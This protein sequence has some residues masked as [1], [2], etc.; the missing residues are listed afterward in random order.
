[1]FCGKTGRHAEG[2]CQQA[3]D[4]G[5]QSQLGKTHPELGLQRREQ[6]GERQ[7]GH[8][9]GEHRHQRGGQRQPVPLLAGRKSFQF[10]LDERTHAASHLV[11]VPVSRVDDV[12][13]NGQDWNA[14]PFKRPFDEQPARCGGSHPLGAEHQCPVDTMA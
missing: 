10:L 1:M 5:E 13:S 12:G 14:C 9:Q 3:V 2:D 8:L 4:A 7:V 11:G 6:R